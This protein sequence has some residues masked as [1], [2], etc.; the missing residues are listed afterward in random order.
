MILN[1]ASYIN[2]SDKPNPPKADKPIICITMGDPSGIGAEIIAKS[3]SSPVVRKLAYFIIVGDAFV[4]KKAFILTKAGFGY[5]TVAQAKKI[6]FNDCNV[7][8]LDLANV[9]SEGFEYGCIKAEYGKAS[10]DYIRSA[11]LLIQNK[12]ADAMVTAPINKYSAKRTGFKYQGHTE[13]LTHLAKA[14]DTAMMLTG[15][16]L[17]VVLA[18]T[19]L[20]LA[21]VSSSLKKRNLFKVIVLIDEWMGYYFGV[22]SCK[23]GVCGLNPHAGEKGAMGRE[24]KD[25]I[26]PAIELAKSKGVNASGPYPSDALFYRAY[27]G[28]F[29]VILCMYHDQALIPLKMVARDEAVNITLGLPF[30]R[31]SPA[32]GTAFDIAGKNIANPASFSAA[33]KTASS[34][35]V[36]KRAVSNE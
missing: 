22:E 19:H 28:D 27:N 21:D 3:L 10:I 16:P 5:K 2:C 25:I 8:L 13:F 17:S 15:G 34:I 29:D 24:E 33:I 6:K 18:T 35:S 32:H 7:L 36:H 23:I 20:P 1:E 31:T 26:T 12:K 4:F 30:I 14:K 9:N 11:Y